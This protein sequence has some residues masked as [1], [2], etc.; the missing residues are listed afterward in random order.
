M[1]RFEQKE[2]CRLKEAY[3]E[4]QEA[5]ND[6]LGDMDSDLAASKHAVEEA[7]SQLEAW[8]NYVVQIIAAPLGMVAIFE[9][10]DGHEEVIPVS[11][12]A[13]H[14]SGRV[15]P[16]VFMGNCQAQ[17]PSHAASFL[18]IDFSHFLISN[19]VPFSDIAREETEPVVASMEVWPE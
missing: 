10:R 14:R 4:A 12:L 8:E 17:Q 15:A 13:L 5:F 18:R 3:R 2:R 6:A 16:Y 19:E 7:L 11:Y 1:S 9:R